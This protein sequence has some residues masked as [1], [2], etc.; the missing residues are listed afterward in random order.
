MND[1]TKIAIGVVSGLAIGIAITYFAKPETIKTEVKTVEVVKKEKENI[2]IDR[3][4]TKEIKP[5]GTVK[6]IITEKDRSK[7]DRQER[8][9]EEVKLVEHVNPK[10]FGLG[11][12]YKGNALDLPNILD[13]K[14][15]IGVEALYKT[16]L[17]GLFIQG[18][19]FMDAT[20]IGTIG[21]MF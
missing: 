6:E 9:D 8:V 13:Y 21:I 1:I 19:V 3:V 7:I 20:V 11:V 17:F 15:N 2:F 5:D 16:D 4:I 18:Q 10:V 14:H 12:S